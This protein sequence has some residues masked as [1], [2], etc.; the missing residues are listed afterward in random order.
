MNMNGNLVPMIL[1]STFGLC[2]I[3]YLIAITKDSCKFHNLHCHA[4]KFQI[5]MT[6]VNVHVYTCTLI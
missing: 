6:H 5:W 2:T 4:Y 1:W 3:N